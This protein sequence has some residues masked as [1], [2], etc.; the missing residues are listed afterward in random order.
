MT[1]KSLLAAGIL[2]STPVLLWI[3]AF[4]FTDRFTT[5]ML[6]IELSASAIALTVL[7]VGAFQHSSKR[8]LFVFCAAATVTN[9][10]GALYLR[11][12]SPPTDIGGPLLALL[13]LAW[14]TVAAAQLLAV[15]T[16]EFL[17]FRKTA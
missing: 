11:F 16:R 4:T 9:A 8:A 7:V 13:A 15:A 1:W 6:F 3:G 14:V 10:L 2:L 12:W 17:R 5:L